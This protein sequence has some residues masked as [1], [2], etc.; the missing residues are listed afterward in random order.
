MTN[1][2]INNSS[3]ESKDVACIFETFALKILYHKGDTKPV[4][5]LG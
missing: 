3:Y 5:Q 4:G 1:D 2:I